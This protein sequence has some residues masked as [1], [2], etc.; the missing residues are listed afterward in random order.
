MRPDNRISHLNIEILRQSKD[1]SRYGTPQLRNNAL[2]HRVHPLSAK[3]SFRFPAATETAAGTSHSTISDKPPLCQPPAHCQAPRSTSTIIQKTNRAVSIPFSGKAVGQEQ[4]VGHTPKP[5]PAETA[6]CRHRSF[7]ACGP[8]RLPEGLLR[9]PKNRRNC[10]IHETAIVKRIRTI[11][12][13][14][15]RSRH[16]MIILISIAHSNRSQNTTV[17]FHSRDCLLRLPHVFCRCSIMRMF[18]GA[19]LPNA[20]PSS[21]SDAA[22]CVNNARIYFFFRMPTCFR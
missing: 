15:T 7:R 16:R 14:H 2:L 3:P 9:S 21:F 13:P 8:G 19:M 18:L 5:S 22:A 17:S 10:Y 1:F 11:I 12:L 20:N 4:A 6:P